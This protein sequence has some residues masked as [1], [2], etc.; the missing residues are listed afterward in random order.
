MVIFLSFVLDIFP[1]VSISYCGNGEMEM[2]GQHCY[3]FSYPLEY[4]ETAKTKCE[5]MEATLASIHS[6]EEAE[7]INRGMRAQSSSYY[8]IGMKREIGKNCMQ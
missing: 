7:Y 2:W 8:W 3:Y 6:M 5:A 1:V 4:W